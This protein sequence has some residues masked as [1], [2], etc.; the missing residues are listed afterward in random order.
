MHRIKYPVLLAIVSWFIMAPALPAQDKEAKELAKKLEAKIS[1]KDGIDANTPLKD[2]LEFLA[3]NQQITI[4]VDLKAFEKAGAQKLVEQPVQLKP[5]KD[6]ALSKVLQMLLD[7]V[8]ATY[9]T[10]K[11]AVVV[12]PK[13]KK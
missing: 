9:K 4:L 8:N 3:D 6:V 1:L 2:A 7:Q 5:V 10:D 12:V 13:P 11:G